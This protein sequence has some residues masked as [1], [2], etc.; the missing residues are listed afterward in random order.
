MT[1]RQPFLAMVPA[2]VLASAQEQHV[3]E[4]GM[5]AGPGCIAQRTLK[6]DPRI[7]V[8]EGLHRLEDFRS[9]MKIGRILLDDGRTWYFDELQ[10][11][12]ERQKGEL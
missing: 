3:V 12:R 11:R 7:S 5:G 10:F 2:A 9:E 1:P 6:F 8:T 4:I